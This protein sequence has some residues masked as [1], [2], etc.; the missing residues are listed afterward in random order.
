[1][2]KNLILTSDS[3]KY[4][5]FLQLPPGTQ[6]QYSY[7]EAR[8]P[9]NA[10]VQRTLFFGLQAFVKEYLLEPITMADIDE[11]EA[12]VKAH[13]EPFNREGWEY[14]L[15]EHKGLLP[16][17][18]RAVPEGTR[19]GY[20]NV[21][22]TVENTDEKV[23]WL[24][25]FMET[26]ILRAVWY[27]T[28]VASNSRAIRDILEQY[29]AISSDAPNLT[30]DFKLHDFGARGVSSGESAMIGGM[31]H[32]A[33]GWLGTDTIEAIMGARR[34]YGADMP[35][36]S[37]PAAEH[38]TITS[39]GE[40]NEVDAYRNML[41]AFDSPLVAVVSDSYDI[42]NACKNIWGDEL[43]EEIKASGKT[44]IIRP[45]SGVPEEVVPKVI[46][47]LID[48]FGCSFNSKGYRVLP[49]YIRVIQGDGIDIHSI[50][51][52]LDAMI[53]A[54][55]SIDNIAF[56]MGGG[57]LQHC[58]RDTFAF[59]MKCSQLKVNDEWR[60]VYKRPVE[61]GKSSKAGRLVL[62]KND[63]GE[64]RT[65]RQSKENHEKNCLEAVYY[66]GAICAE[67]GWDEVLKR[68]AA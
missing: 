11:A 47:I 51:K 36:F 66:N 60:D 48:Q 59:A 4:S 16:L 56:G 53:G 35:G 50:P 34:Y 3:Y 29:W 10:G 63:F 38:S 2:K 9:S 52:I 44:V 5:H 26:A 49:D 30:L 57:L 19:V 58:N 8:A 31:A 64:F 41:T 1:M 37:I 40:E 24:T 55:L 54:G 22:V 12:I 7:I 25:S 6:R 68:S 13:G 21:L 20:H 43:K 27:P 46:N 42:Y 14:I 65:E 39:W 15:N 17:N 18:I 62:L 67:Y 33:A 32:L 28:T 45:D 61:G 23:P